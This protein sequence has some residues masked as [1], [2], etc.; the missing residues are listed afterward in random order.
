SLSKPESL[1]IP[2]KCRAI[3]MD[4]PDGLILA[5]ASNPS[6][7]PNRIR[8]ITPDDR[9]NRAVQDYYEPGSTFK[10]ITASAG[11]EEGVV[12][13]SQILDCANGAL[14]VANVVIH[15][16]GHNRYGLLSFEDVMVHSSNIGAVR[17]GVAVGPDRFYRWIHRFGFGE[18]TGIPLP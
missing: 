16:H 8:D 14:P 13:P 9:R 4:P 15:E 12:T 17:V 7:D 11:L 2:Y 10:I 1:S 6:Y 18:R 5:M 3:V